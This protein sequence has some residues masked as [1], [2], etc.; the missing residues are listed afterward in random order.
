MNIIYEE[1]INI[2][3]RKLFLAGGKVGGHLVLLRKE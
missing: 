1:N 2:F 3:S